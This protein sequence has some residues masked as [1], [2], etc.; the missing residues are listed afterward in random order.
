MVPYNNKNFITVLAYIK[1]IE[2]YKIKNI[3][4]LD[5]TARLALV[6][7]FF[8]KC[9]LKDKKVKGKQVPFQ[10]PGLL[11]AASVVCV[12]AFD[13]GGEHAAVSSGHETDAVRVY[14]I[15]LFILTG[16]TTTTTTTS[17][18]GGGNIVVGEE[19]EI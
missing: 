12:C 10:R 5:F 1:K 14:N 9:W 7:I 4:V 19:E 11:I 3:I 6:T 2:P 8:F 15:Y 16:P 13:V 18:R 17:R